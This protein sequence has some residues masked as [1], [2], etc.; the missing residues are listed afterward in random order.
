M[1][2]DI[3]PTNEG[4]EMWSTDSHGIRNVKGDVIAENV[5]I[6]IN[7]AVWWD[8]DLLREMLDRERISKYDWT[9]QQCDVL[10][11][12]SPECRFNNSSKSNPCL[13]A[14]IVGDW[15]EEVM[16][17]TADSRELRI[18][19]TTLPTQ[20]RLPCLMEDI[21]YRLSVATENVGYNQP[22]ETGF[23]LGEK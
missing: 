7:F 12:F 20:Y 14:D 13:S 23:Y 2:A 16:V 22:P 18:Y 11:N 3:D 1:A 9:T 4:V 5:R 19:T 6:P 10:K 21:P 15:R 8:G 17:R